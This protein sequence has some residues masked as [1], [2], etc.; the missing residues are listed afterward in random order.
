MISRETH[1]SLRETLQEMEKTE[2]ASKDQIQAGLKEWREVAIPGLYQSVK[3]MLADLISDGLVTV[4]PYRHERR[5]EELTGPY[6]I[7]VMDLAIR[8]RTL[9][10][11]PV[12]RFVFGDAIGR[13]E[14]S[15]RGRLDR[16]Y[17][18]LRHKDDSGKDRWFFFSEKDGPRK[19]PITNLPELSRQ[20]LEDMI[21]K[22]L[23]S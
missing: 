15:S 8:G 23:V 5:T 22:L 4:N 14:L 9:T 13:V 16:R 17:I 10:L 11:N 7:E 6:E 1:M 18:L 2:E 3:E 19:L 20:T 21:E 12:A